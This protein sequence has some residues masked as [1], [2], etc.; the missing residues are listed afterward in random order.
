[1]ESFHLQCV[2]FVEGMNK[3][4]GPDPEP[5]S[6][7]G[8]SGAVPPCSYLKIKPKNSR[9]KEA[10]EGGDSGVRPSKLPRTFDY[11]KWWSDQ[12][13]IGSD[14]KVRF[15]NTEYL[16]VNVPFEK[17]TYLEDLQKSLPGLEIIYSPNDLILGNEISSYKLDRNLCFD[18]CKTRLKP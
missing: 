7:A 15:R 6:V 4:V 14:G 17:D 13:E 2:L 12:Y 16:T 3:G 18:N 5:L 10:A 1:M 11:A 8:G 9:A